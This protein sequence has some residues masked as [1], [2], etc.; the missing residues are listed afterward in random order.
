MRR[1]DRE[2]IL[3]NEVENIIKGC[4]VCR[5]GLCRDGKAYIVPLSFGYTYKGGRLTMYFHSAD[6]GRKIEILKHSPN[7]FF[8][9]DCRHTLENDGDASCC[10]MYYESVMGEGTA[11]FIEG[12]DE[13]TAALNILTAHYGGKSANYPPELLAKTAVIKVTAQSLTAK[14]HAPKKA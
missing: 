5:L 11:E 4:D 10:T 2:I 1:N 7:V 12:E 3:P 9:M 8:E 13:K 14:K 6:A